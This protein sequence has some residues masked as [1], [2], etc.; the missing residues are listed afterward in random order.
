MRGSGSL[1]AFFLGRLTSSGQRCD[2]SGARVAPRGTMLDVLVI[3][4]GIAGLAAAQRLRRAGRSVLV[5]EARDR[6]GGRVR[7]LRGRELPCP[8]EAGAEFVHGRPPALL[9]VL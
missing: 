1:L 9:R 7:T 4:A 3:G 2:S 8:I 5:L 6:V